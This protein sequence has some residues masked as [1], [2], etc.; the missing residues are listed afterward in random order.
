M[1]DKRQKANDGKRKMSDKICGAYN[2]TGCKAAATCRFVHKYDLWAGRYY[3]LNIVQKL[4][5]QK[6]LIRD[7]HYPE[8]FKDLRMRN[9]E[10]LTNTELLELAKMPPLASKVKPTTAKVADSRK[11]VGLKVSIHVKPEAAKQ[12]S[13]DMKS[14]LT[15]GGH[16]REVG[17]RGVGAYKAEA[18]PRRTG[19]EY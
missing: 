7:S 8:E 16:R 10:S 11:K 17:R 9:K 6:G 19:S 1:A 3:F 14:E 13:T 15:V 5:Q 12:L 4:Q 2:H 18:D